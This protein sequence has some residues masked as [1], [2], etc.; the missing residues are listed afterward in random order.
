MTSSALEKSTSLFPVG[1]T[2]LPAELVDVALKDCGRGIATTAADFTRD[3]LKIAQYLSPPLDP[4]D[5]LYMPELRA[6]QYFV[7]SVFARD[8]VTAIFVDYIPCHIQWAQNRGGFVARYLER[9]SE[10]VQV[11]KGGRWTAWAMP[12]GDDLTETKELYGIY[13][14]VPALFSC[15]STFIS[16][17]RSMQSQFASYRHPKDPDKPLPS[18]IR[19]YD[20]R[21]FQKVGP[22]GKRWFMPTL[23]G[24]DWVTRAEYDRAHAFYEVIRGSGS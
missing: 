12:N 18:Y 23:R 2:P 5:G 8:S 22:G 15:T 11:D 16:F 13:D 17:A 9:P 20:L 1:D 21:T 7:Q 14:G 6:G 19:K 24:S 4:A 3:Q 10:A